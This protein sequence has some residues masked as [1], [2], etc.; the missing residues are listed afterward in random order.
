MPWGFCRMCSLPYCVVLWLTG[1][2]QDYEVGLVGVGVGTAAAGT[3]LLCIQLIGLD[4]RLRDLETN[5][6]SKMLSI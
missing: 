3:G 5:S 1:V 2:I 6:I 4:L